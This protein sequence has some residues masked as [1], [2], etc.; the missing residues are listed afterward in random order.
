MEKHEA[1]LNTQNLNFVIPIEISCSC[2]Y[3]TDFYL[4]I[5]ELG[6][7]PLWCQIANVSKSAWMALHSKDT[8]TVKA[9][10]R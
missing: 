6:D 1:Q 8:A 4:E 5:F 3:L 10:I 2:F 7:V 9:T